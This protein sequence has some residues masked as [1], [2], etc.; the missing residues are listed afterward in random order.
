[1]KKRIFTVVIAAAVVISASITSCKSPE[2]KVENAV[3]KVEDAK[4]NLQEVIKDSNVAAEKAATAEEWK[5][6][7]NVAEVTIKNNEIRINELKSK[8]KNAGVTA[9]VM[10]SKKIE[11]LE[12]QNHN[13][14]VKIDNY[15]KNHSDWEAFKREFN[16]DVDGLGQAFK[17]L[18]VKNK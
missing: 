17:D 5:M 4:Q 3:T 15:D 12:Q 13:L 7:K 6:F 14:K 11:D 16:H 18:T 10:Y 2:Q 1:M 9:D 8:M